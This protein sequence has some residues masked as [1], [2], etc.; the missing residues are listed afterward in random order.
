[1]KPGKWEEIEQIKDRVTWLYQNGGR[2]PRSC[3]IPTEYLWLE[4]VPAPVSRIVTWY[5]KNAAVFLKSH[6]EW[7]GK[8]LRLL[9]A[10]YP[11]IQ[12][13]LPPER[14]VWDIYIWL[15]DWKGSPGPGARK[16]RK[17]AVLR[18]SIE[19]NIGIFDTEGSTSR[20]T[21]I[22]WFSQPLPT[23]FKHSRKGWYPP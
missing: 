22:N 11:H 15:R 18:S 10:C 17:K 5:K 4:Q 3:Y 7:R 14:N 1:M 13:S 20:R 6:I 2:S 21:Q 12:T 19:Y 23:A 9:H 8:C 16:A